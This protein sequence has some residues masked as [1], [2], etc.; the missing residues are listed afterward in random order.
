M[1]ISVLILAVFTVAAGILLFTTP[2]EAEAQSPEEDTSISSTPEEDIVEVPGVYP[3]ETATPPP[4]IPETPEIVLEVSSLTITYGN[5]PLQFKNEFSIKVGERIELGARIEPP[6]VEATPEWSS[7]DEEIFA[8]VPVVG[9]VAV[10]GIKAG[11]AT[12]TLTVGNKT[13]EC[14]V[15]VTN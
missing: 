8:A 15:R 12:L 13:E 6:G 3:E 9:G 5:A 7:S 11:N 1:L 2:D 14:T 10:T 4:E